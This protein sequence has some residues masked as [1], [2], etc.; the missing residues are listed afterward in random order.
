LYLFGWFLKVE[1][2]YAYE[3][4]GKN[5]E[6]LAKLEE[7]NSKPFGAIWNYFCLKN[8]VLAGDDYIAEIQQ[9]EKTILSNR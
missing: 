7:A 6:K 5:F 8:N 9:Y 3:E 2:I 4:K 1:K